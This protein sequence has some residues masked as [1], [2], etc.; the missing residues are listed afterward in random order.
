SVFAFRKDFKLKFKRVALH[1]AYI[2]FAHPVTK[3]LLEFSAPM[4]SDMEGF[5]RNTR[6][7]NKGTHNLFPLSETGCRNR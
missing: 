4:P 6:D 1:A 2:R 5:L 3:K 7:A